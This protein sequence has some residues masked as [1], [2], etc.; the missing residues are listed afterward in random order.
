M[1]GLGL[2][3]ADMESIN[4]L[5]QCFLFM[6]LFYATS[7][8]GTGEDGSPTLAENASSDDAT[9]SSQSEEDLDAQVER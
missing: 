5:T 8:L 6:F 2:L 4:H 7:L 1:D 3:C 9:R